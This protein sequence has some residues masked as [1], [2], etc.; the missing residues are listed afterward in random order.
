MA[1]FAKEDLDAIVSAIGFG[2][3]SDFRSLQSAMGTLAD[4]SAENNRIL[5]DVNTNL[6]STDRTLERLERHL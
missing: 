6:A 5:G 4:Q 3:V 2:I 1:E